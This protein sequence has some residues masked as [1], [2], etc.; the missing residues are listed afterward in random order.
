MNKTKKNI[1]LVGFND[2][3]GKSIQ[4]PPI[5]KNYYLNNMNEAKNHQGY[6]IIINNKDNINLVEFD[7]KYRKILNKYVNVW[8]YN[9]KYNDTYNKWSNIRMVNRDIFLFDSLY[10]WDQY[11][12]YKYLVEHETVNKKY[13]DKRLN[14]IANLHNYLKKYSTIKTSKISHDL[15]INSRMIQR[16]MKDINDIYN[17][18]GYDYSNNEWYVV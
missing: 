5:G 13:T 18:I 14:N 2:V 11:D 4:I 17:N 16:Y 10:F 8:L 1:I 15:K 9:E 12:E 3:E 6:L 7:K